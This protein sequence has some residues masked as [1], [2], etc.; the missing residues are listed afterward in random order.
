MGGFFFTVHMCIY[1]I[2]L[3]GYHVPKH[4]FGFLPLLLR[5]H[6]ALFLLK[7]I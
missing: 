7:A 1:I 3:S 4:V 6:P 2:V 5:H